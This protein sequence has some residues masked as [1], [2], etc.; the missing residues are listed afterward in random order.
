MVC[1]LSSDFQ[2]ACIQVRIF[3][4]LPQLKSNIVN[5]DSHISQYAKICEEQKKEVGQPLSLL[6]NVAEVCTKYS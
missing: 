4:F 1:L 6:A 2:F 3:L 5:V